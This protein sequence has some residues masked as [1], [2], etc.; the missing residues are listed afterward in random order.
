MWALGKVTFPEQTGSEALPYTKISGRSLPC[1]ISTKDHKGEPIFP[2][3]ICSPSL[4]YI[5]KSICSF[6]R[7]GTVLGD[8]LF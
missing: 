8:S 7:L 1:W 4:P 5:K 3:Q 6:A 2:E